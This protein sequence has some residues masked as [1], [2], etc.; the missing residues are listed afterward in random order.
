[1]L[2]GLLNFIGEKVADDGGYG[3]E[4]EINAALSALRGPDVDNRFTRELRAMVGDRI[5]HAVLDEV[6]DFEYSVEKRPLPKGSAKKLKKLL[7][8]AGDSIPLHYLRHLAVAVDATNNHAVWA[9]QANG[10]SAEMNDAADNRDGG[11][12]AILD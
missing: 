2:K 7:D 5:R 4:Q 9:G 1:M 8:D 11:E 12:G 3:A 6:D 10:I